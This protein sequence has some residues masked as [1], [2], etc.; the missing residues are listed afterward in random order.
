MQGHGA[1][2]DSG[3]G[4]RHI[5]LGVPSTI[6]VGGFLGI[7]TTNSSVRHLIDAEPSGTVQSAQ[8]AFAFNPRRRGGEWT[9]AD[10]AS[11]RY[12]LWANENGFPVTFDASN[13]PLIYIVKTQSGK[14]HA[15]F[16]MTDVQSLNRFPEQ[17]KSEWVGASPGDKGVIDFPGN[18]VEVSAL[19]ARVLTAVQRHGNVLLYGPPGTGKTLLMQQIKSILLSGG[20]PGLS[21]DP[22]DT[23]QPFR[24]ANVPSYPTPIICGWVTFHQ[25]TSYEDFIVGLRPKPVN[26]GVELEARAGLLL[27][28]S[29]KV[30]TSGGSAFVFIDEINRGNVS[31][32]FGE[33]VTLIE[34][35]KRL[36]PNGQQVS[37]KTVEVSI[38]MLDATNS[39]K[40]PDG[41][42]VSIPIPYTM[43]YHIYLIASMNSLDRSVMPLDTA[44]ARRFFRFEMAVDYDALGGRLGI[45]APFQRSETPNS[46]A[47][48]AIALL[49]RVNEI[50][51]A[52]LGDDFQLGQSYVWNVGEPGLD[53]DGKW[54]ELIASWENAILPQVVELLRANPDYL[55]KLLRATS[56]GRPSN[57]PYSREPSGES[58]EL[59]VDPAVRRMPL[60]KL[61]LDDRKNA[62]RFLARKT[63]P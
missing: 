31:K 12:P 23:S 15:R 45:Q 21:I 2:A 49:Y 43:P 36:G 61:S 19:V 46:A 3:G 44:L 25:T 52:A 41:T 16:T 8:I 4:A 7:Q 50:L 14:Y 57:Y 1:L 38:P 60:S 6:D 18:S 35:D 27:T 5:P 47:E 39:V 53:E 48:V 40:L 55:D 29:E 33:F 37:G 58:R 11:N 62:L 42:S 56:G 20:Q 17:L 54:K 51:L 30:R 10:Q 34:R 59:E 32:V 24:Q 9:I 26:G 63:S 28:L 22:S 13:P